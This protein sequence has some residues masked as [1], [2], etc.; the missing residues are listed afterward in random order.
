M[1]IGKM[2]TT[3]MNMR[4]YLVLCNSPLCPLVSKE[5]GCFVAYQWPLGARGTMH[6]F[7]GSLIGDGD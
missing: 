4:T 7:I 1:P 5:E 3:I 6:V 2:E